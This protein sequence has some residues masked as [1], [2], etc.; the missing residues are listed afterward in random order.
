MSADV[1]YRDAQVGGCVEASV[2]A[3]PDGSVIVRSTEGLRWFPDRPGP[4]PPEGVVYD[5]DV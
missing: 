1:R 5:L 4:T 3:R 2:Q